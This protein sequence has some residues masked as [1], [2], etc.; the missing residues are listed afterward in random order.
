MVDPQGYSASDETDRLTTGAASWA[1]AW[2]RHAVILIFV[3]ATYVLAGKLGLALASVNASA[4]AVWPPS[5]IALAAVLI[6]GGPVWPGIFLGAF[7]TNVTTAGTLTTSVL[8]AAGNTLEALCGGYLVNRFAGGRRAFHNVR[9]IFLFVLLAG[10]VSTCV[11]ATVGVTSLS[12]FGF[13]PW[14]AYG[15]IWLTWWLGDMVGA[16]VV[17]PVIL[18][19]WAN[20]R[21]AWTRTQRVEFLLSLLLSVVAGW[22]VFI[23]ATYPLIFLAIPIGLWVGFRFG[24]REAA[25]A[26]WALSFP[27]TWGAAHGLGAFAHMPPNDALLVAQAFMAVTTLVG[28][29]VG[30]AVSERKQFFA[31]GRDLFG[32]ADFSGRFRRV[33]PAFSEVLG[34][35]AEE[36]LAQPFLEF[37]HPDDRAATRA[38][39]ERLRAGA[40]TVNFSNRYRCHDGSWRRLS[41]TSVSVPSE[42]LIYATARDVTALHEAQ[43]SVRRREEYL[44]VVLNSIGDAVMVTD[45]EGRV[46]GLNVVA[47]RLTGWRDA[48]AT[49]RPV[50][51]VFRIIYAE[52]RQPAHIPVHETL[53][54]GAIHGLGN[55]TVLIARDGTERPIADSCA[56]IRGRDGQVVGAVLIFRDVTDDYASKAALRASEQRLRAIVDNMAAFVG[57]MT[58]DGVLV[59]ANRAALDAGG[60]QREEVIGKPLDET[61]WFSYSTAVRD[62]T[63]EDI[64]R[65]RR[66]E[67]VRHDLD[68]RMAGGTLLNI[69]F[70]LVPVRDPAGRVIKLIPSGVDI[71]ERKRVEQQ[72]RDLND[73][74]E[75]LVTERTGAL[76]QSERRF[77]DLF[78]SAPD[79]IVITDRQGRIT[80]VN[81]QAER[82]F[83]WTRAEL[84]GQPVE[85]LMPPQARQGHVAL[86]E[87]YVQSQTGPRAMGAGRNLRAVRRNG[88]EFPVEISLS[89]MES[90]GEIVVAAAVRDITERKH[91]E[92]QFLQSQ[93]MEGLGHLAGGIAHDFNNLLTII[94]GTTELAAEGLRDADP[95]RQDLA[96]IRDAATKA[97]ALTRQLLA[98]SRKQILQPAIVNLNTV[99]ADAEAMLRRL[100]GEHIDMIVHLGEAL[101]SVRVD[102][103]QIE[104]VILN[105]A[106]NSRDAMPQGGTLTIETGNV[107][108]TEADT[109][110]RAGLQPGPYV[111]LVITDT[112]IGMDDATREQMFEPF[113]TTKSPGQGTGLGL[114]TSYGI[115]K[116]SGG[117]VAVDS[118]VGH[119]TTITIYLPRADG[120]APVGRTV[121]TATAARGTESILVVEDEAG[122]RKMV[123]RMLG[124][125]GYTVLVAANGKEALELL[126]RQDGPIHMLLTDVVMPGMSGRELAERVRDRY[127]AMKILYTSGYTD[128]AIMHHGVLD[129]GMHFIGKPYATAVLTRKVRE[130]L[131]S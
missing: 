82:M 113:F 123:T 18:L 100:I 71:S 54:Q 90:E 23:V 80:L 124:A 24:Q 125:A 94:H 101:A 12:L 40:S 115:V 38:E 81:G 119:G 16:V 74:L 51:D 109:R 41:W 78:E 31:L 103:G 120:A 47:E 56:P 64:E 67:V 118:H 43:E 11:S 85:R 5:G 32:I 44:A 79:A 53:A 76:R 106:I 98:F 29:T 58:P 72:I 6:F 14:S 57:E 73:G 87:H 104:Q 130:V 46:T 62:Q 20:P 105:L 131:D 60:L 37:V 83:G 108:L 93:K 2:V 77:A 75:Q 95:L 128:D 111:R 102:P 129:E 86:R 26:T 52:T 21:I 88:E 22:V 59:E 92:A 45:A 17:A 25:T 96:T 34:W 4:T 91:L 49:G 65:A 1:A 27:A 89:P 39:M 55:D 30:A 9:D 19:W 122:I 36:L 70:M 99:V 33:N 66:G 61:W 8:I 110:T 117:D 97:A 127:P 63:R 10:L 3:A 35:T 68:V 7:L 50:D 126:D 107:V 42:G 112:G 114:S 28:L 121:R 69:D 15:P 13:A 116:Q 48:E 84:M